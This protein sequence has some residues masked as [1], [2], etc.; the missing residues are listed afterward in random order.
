MADKKAAYIKPLLQVRSPVGVT[1]KILPRRF[2]CTA[3][4]SGGAS[5]MK[6]HLRLKI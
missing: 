1:I 6:Q 2:Y 3:V 4:S 5:R